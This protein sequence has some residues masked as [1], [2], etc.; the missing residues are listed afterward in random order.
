MKK[1]GKSWISILCVIGV[2]F[3]LAPGALA[4]GTETAQTAAY[5]YAS[6]PSPQVGSIGGDWTVLGLARS[7]YTVEDGYYQAYYQAVE[8]YVLAAQGDLSSTKNT[9]YARL[10]L[11]LAAIGADPTD[12]GGYNLLLPLGDQGATVAQGVNGAI[13]ALIALDAGDYAVPEAPDTAIQASRTGYV[14]YILDRQLADGGWAMSGDAADPDV[15]AMALVALS[16]Y[17]DQAAEAIAAGLDCLSGL[18]TSTGGF[19]SWGGENV[20]TTAQ[21]MIAL[22][23]LG[24]EVEDARFV[25]SGVSLLDNLAAYRLADGSYSHVPDGSSNRM[26]TEQAML[27]LAALERAEAGANSLFAMGDV[28]PV[29]YENAGAAIGL[30]GKHEDVVIPQV[31]DPGKTFDDIVYY[32]GRQAVE[33]LAARG[34]IQGMTTTEFCPDIPMTRAQFA[35]VVVRSLGLS[36]QA[37]LTFADVPAD[38]WYTAYIQAAFAYGLIQGRSET[39]FDP[40]G[41]ITRQEAAALLTRAAKLCGIQVAYDATAQRNVLSQFLDYTGSA[42][43]AGEGL[44][45]C[46]DQDILDQAELYIRYDDPVLRGEM[47]QMLYRLLI[48]AAFI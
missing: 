5:L 43:W 47:A 2:L 25:K 24:I 27:A 7:G 14:A 48:L 19:A 28:E 13:W 11:S 15:T 31:T 32:D 8:R 35:A 34:I 36:A 9:E 4:L 30:P 45:F 38:A 1:I 37:E 29:D 33:A 22:C 10:I 46:Y 40:D 6:T 26:A 12:V 23:S 41:A 20:E 21:V 18:Q 39:I 44:A 42:A 16:P 3:G 17:Q